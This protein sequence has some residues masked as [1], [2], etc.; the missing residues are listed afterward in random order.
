MT[1]KPFERHKYR[2]QKQQQEV[3]G[4]EGTGLGSDVEIIQRDEKGLRRLCLC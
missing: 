4:L 2:M 3:P 1:P